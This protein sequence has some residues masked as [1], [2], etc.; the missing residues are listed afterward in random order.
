MR[1]LW[2]ETMPNSAECIIATFVYMYAC[3][4]RFPFWPPSQF[5]NASKRCSFP[6]VFFAAAIASAVLDAGWYRISSLDGSCPSGEFDFEE[7]MNV[8]RHRRFCRGRHGVLQSL[9]LLHVP[10]AHATAVTC[11]VDALRW[12]LTVRFPHGHSGQFTAGL[13]A[14][15]WAA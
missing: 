15:T 10:F 13:T 3:S 1:A 2:G 14:D 5:S 9:P 4:L 8:D 7:K 11:F 6:N 12:T